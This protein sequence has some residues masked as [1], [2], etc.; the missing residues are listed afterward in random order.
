MIYEIIIIILLLI[1]GNI[2]F[3]YEDKEKEAKINKQRLLDLKGYS[4]TMINKILNTKAVPYHNYLILIVSDPSINFGYEAHPF[5]RFIDWSDY[6]K[7]KDIGNIEIRLID[8]SKI[9]EITH[10]LETDLCEVTVAKTYR[11]LNR[12]ITYKKLE[13]MVTKS[14]L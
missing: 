13:E 8:I 1:I 10:K 12:N 5:A 4:L 2:L 14:K 6:N 3:Y 7:L 9:K 11:F